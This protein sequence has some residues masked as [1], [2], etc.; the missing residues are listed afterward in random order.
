MLTFVFCII[1]MWIGYLWWKKLF[2]YSGPEYIER[3]PI[4]MLIWPLSVLLFLIHKTA[5]LLKPKRDTGSD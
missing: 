4:Y 2:L 3:I 1:Y 5:R